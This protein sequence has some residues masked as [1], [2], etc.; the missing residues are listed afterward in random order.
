MVD[1]VLADL[2]GPGQVEVDCGDQRAV[3]RDEEVT[4]DRR[5]HSDQELGRNAERDA[6]RHQRAS[7][8]RLAVEQDRREEEPE[9]EGPR[10]GLGHVAD[11]GTITSWLAPM[12]LSP[13]HAR[14]K[15]PMTATTP[16]RSV[17]VFGTSSTGTFVATSITAATASMTISITIGMARGPFAP[18]R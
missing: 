10:G 7:G 5:E 2:R 11:R 6:Q 1:H 12:K 18:G 15:M 3:G 13:S 17:A 16:A 4:V 14:P 8:G 9:R